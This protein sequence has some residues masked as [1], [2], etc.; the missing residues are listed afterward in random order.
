MVVSARAGDTRNRGYP[1]VDLLGARVWIT[2][3]AV[4]LALLSGCAGQPQSYT[5][6]PGGPTN[7]ARSLTCWSIFAWTSAPQCIQ[8]QFGPD[9]RDKTD[10]QETREILYEMH[11][12]PPWRE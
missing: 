7:P 11:Q 2:F 9:E 1:G 6:G 3:F 8:I 10:A 5:G 4:V 12:R